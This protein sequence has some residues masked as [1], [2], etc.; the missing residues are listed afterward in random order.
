MKY[1]IEL[2]VRGRGVELIELTEDEKN[3]LLKEKCLND[4]YL[5]WVDECGYNFELERYFLTPN[6]DR[7]TLTIRDENNNVVYESE[8]VMELEDRTFDDDGECQVKGWTFDGVKDGYYLTRIQTI[9][10]CWYE[11]E[12]EIDGTFD[13]DKL[14]VVQDKNIEEELLGDYVFPLGVIYYQKGDGYDMIRDEIEL[15]FI[16]DFGEQYWDTRLYKLRYKC[17]WTNLHKVKE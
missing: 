12:F 13:K 2:G 5:D 1:F 7:F 6:V 3:K 9:K 15:E 10:G 4:V 16:S 8:D 11:G 17:S 14:Y